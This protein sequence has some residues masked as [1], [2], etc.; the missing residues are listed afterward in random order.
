VSDPTSSSGSYPSP[1]EHPRFD[2]PRPSVPAQRSQPHGAF[3]P[4]AVAP[5]PPPGHPQPVAAGP[6]RRLPVKRLLT[7]GLPALLVA[8]LLAGGL[9]YANR[10]SPVY[11]N[12]DSPA[13]AS[14]QQST[15][16]APPDPALETV[17]DPAVEE[18]RTKALIEKSINDALAA[19]GQALLAGDK[20][21]F[22]GF[23]DPTAKEA[24]PR[25]WLSDRFTT[26][27]A[28]GVTQ[29][30][31]S[32]DSF[33]KNNGWRWSVTV[34]IDYCFASPCARSLTTT[35]ESFWNMATP[36]HPMIEKM[37]D[38]KSGRLAQPW[39]ATVLRT[40]AGS[41]VV[42]AASKANAG[43]LDRTLAA[44]EAAARVADTYATDARP[45][46]YVIYL[47]DDEQWDE[48]SHSRE[49]PYVAGYA[50]EDR[51][52]VVLRMSALNSIPL[53]DLLRHEMTHVASL[54]GASD[55]VNEA[56][57]WWLVE[58]LAEYALLNGKPFATYNRRR[59]TAAFVRAK[60]KGDLRVGAPAKKASQSDVSARYGTAY[61]GVNCLMA[62]YGR[63]KTLAF[64]QEVAVGGYTL[65][66]SST[67]ALGVP[68]STVTSTC[69][70][71]IRRTAL[72]GA[73]AHG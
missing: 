40:K 54:A 13:D 57:S 21:S 46:K 2:A 56:D 50:T 44:A 60:W 1:P 42:V 64:V 17:Y 4:S 25:T 53:A 39:A 59:E 33:V 18:Q 14:G 24:N 66:V 31:A 51:E 29:W 67:R 22:V 36:D 34:K 71:Q 68:W 35:L 72:I 70:A 20:T 52:S 11:A 45:G 6:A 10:D 63:A 5:S 12:R 16:A 58:G 32:V 48:W 55:S 30:N 9:V 73:G 28:L 43:Q 62:T 69:G 7:L 27:R 38:Y 15:A 19:Q 26:L 23:A 47:A 49:G 65:T 3:Q 8:G 41:R 37:W 61:L